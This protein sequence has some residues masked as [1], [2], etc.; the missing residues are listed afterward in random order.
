MLR[1]THGRRKKRRWRV[2]R[3]YLIKEATNG[4]NQ[5]WVGF[6]FTYPSLSN[7][8][9]LGDI[10]QILKARVTDTNK[11]VQS[12][13]LDIIARIATA[14][15]KP[16]EKHSRL[17]TLPISTVLS[18]QKTHVRAVALQTLTAM[19]D[20][21]EGLE[22]MVSGFTTALETQNPLQKATLMQW[23]VDWF[24]GHPLSVDLKG[25]VPHIISSL[26]DR[27]GD[28]RKAAQT[29]LPFL[30]QHAGYDFVLQQTN[31]LKPAS[32]ASAIPLIQAA[33]PTA[34][35]MCAS[36]PPG[37]AITKVVSSSP[38]PPAS[39]VAE[40]VS[41][42]PEAK[43]TS[44][45]AG[46][47]RKLPV[48]TS[49]PD[50]GTETND[51][52][53]KP[54]TTGLKKLI[55]STAT[56]KSSTSTTPVN[57]TLPFTNMNAELK[58]MR[59]AKDANRWVNEGGPTRKDLMELLQGQMEPHTNK[60]LVARLF[61]HD[62][63]AINDHINGLTTLADFYS[64]ASDAD[65]H[66]EKLCLANLDMPLKYVSIKIHEPQ[67]NLV[68]K[69]LDVVEAVLAFLR[70]VNHQISDGEAACFVPTI[71]HKV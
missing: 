47:R 50:S 52:S 10:G 21:C 33:R 45:S 27:N 6:T 55:Q 49:R 20:A 68:S 41:S 3:V 18:D 56:T 1:A 66:L 42:I 38:D 29:L 23:L 64:G 39:P 4:S 34:S 19:A 8:F 36:K 54:T 57:P 70:H 12:L 32:R 9:P 43:P 53:S 25:W 14:M 71:I 5:I 22:S 46:V 62:H 15:G 59:L 26:D 58:K 16:F 17:F 30:I 35:E 40:A 37:P 69:C 63:N 44:K 67:P 31:A 48:G 13:A 51:A 11:A 24:K 28:V 61:S 7:F 2:F 65:D 60:D